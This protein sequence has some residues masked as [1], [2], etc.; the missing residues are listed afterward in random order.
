MISLIFPT[1]NEAGNIKSLI[2]R[3]SKALAGVKHEM[4]VVDDNS[5]DKTWKIVAEL[6]HKLPQLR[7]LRRKKVRG[8]TSALNDG[9]KLARGSIVG[10]MD[11]DLSHPPE[12]LPS[13]VKAMETNDAA[14][15][16][17]YLHGA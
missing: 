16:S 17:R 2:V 12:L 10:W 5:P 3:S 14:V 4:I 15:A 11:A 1:Y 13:L 9:I 6:I 7:L 8:L